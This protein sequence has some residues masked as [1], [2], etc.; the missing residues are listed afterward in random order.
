LPPNID[1]IRAFDKFKIVILNRR[2]IK[3]R[4]Y[5]EKKKLRLGMLKVPRLSIPNLTEIRFYND[6]TN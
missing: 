6:T 5:V 3:I 4:Y 1:E 2:L